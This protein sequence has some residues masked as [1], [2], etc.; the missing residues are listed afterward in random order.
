MTSRSGDPLIG[1]QSRSRRE[2][3]L[4]TLA[5]FASLALLVWLA[6]RTPGGRM[7]HFERGER[8]GPA[9]DMLAGKRPYRETFPVHGFLSDGGLDLLLFSLFG[10][11]FTLSLIAHHLLGVLFQPSLFL[12]AAIATRRPWL[13]AA[14][15]PLNI[16]LATQIIAD[17]PV[18]PL[19]SL[20][21]FLW[22]LEEKPR[23]GRAFA[24]GL[25]AGIGFLYALEFGT[26]VLV[27]ELAT[28]AFIRLTIGKPEERPLA[29]GSFLLGLG[30]AL[31]PFFVYLATVRAL[32]PFLRTSFLDLPLWIHR[33]W[34]WDFPTPWELLTSWAQG[35]PYRVGAL[36]IGIGVAKRLYLAPLLGGL[37]IIL[38]SR[39]RRAF[40]QRPLA[41]RLFAV[42][43]AC[44]C[45]FRYAVARLHLEVGNA[46][47]G[48]IFLLILFACYEVYRRVAPAPRR[49]WAAALLVVAGLLMGLG[50]NAA[51][52][53]FRLF[54]DAARYKERMAARADLVPLTVARGGGA[55][56]P[57]DEARDLA[58][59]VAFFERAVPPESE[60]LDLTNRP[61]LYFFL[62]RRNATRFYQVP[63]MQPFQDEV[64]RVLHNQPPALILLQREIPYDTA[65]GIPNP[66]RIPRVWHDLETTFPRRFRVG[67]TLIALP[68]KPLSRV[69]EEFFQGKGKPVR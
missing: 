12:V 54:R 51:V 61:A 41:L 68:P 59:L 17:R 10:P 50:M 35:R 46:L 6:T 28:L 13:A 55:L 22:A 1:E 62:R 20:A 5:V 69:K 42:S 45:F 26:F 67:D 38:A 24:A 4:L 58:V 37:G 32:I 57:S 63:L 47:T 29:S 14:A 27:G 48:P 18:L 31:V 65:D 7:D 15:I 40:G 56:V 64:L 66:T 23:R 25:L 2:N 53:T 49:R 33:V 19:L 9:S 60:I 36:T 3:L 16:G 39:I 43:V 34:G 52:R 30:V 44:L 11:S 8:L 21:A